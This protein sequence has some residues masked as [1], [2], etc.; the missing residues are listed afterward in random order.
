MMMVEAVLPGIASAII[1]GTFALGETR[2]REVR[3]PGAC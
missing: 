2:S 3:S 1:Y